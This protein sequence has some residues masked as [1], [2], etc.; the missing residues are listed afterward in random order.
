VTAR[1]KMPMAVGG[2]LWFDRKG[3]R[4]LGEKRIALLERIDEVGSITGAAKAVGLSYK[5]AWDAVDAINNMAEESVV[6]R[7]TGGQHGGGSRLTDYGR[8]LVRLYRQLET[9]HQR[10]LSRLESDYPDPQRLSD[11]LKAI[12]M[13]TSARNQFRGKVKAVRRG[14][15]NADV[16][17]DLGDGVE[18]FA[19]ITN[20]AVAELGLKRGRDAVAL[21]KASFVVLATGDDILVSARNRLPGTVD[22][23]V[24]GPV[25]SEVKIQLTGMRTLVAV[26][27]SAGLKE[28]QL[29]K[30]SP[31]FALI[32][33]SHVLIAVN[34]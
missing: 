33:A 24:K 30:G 11:L 19:N 9:G 13:K 17:L 31:V 5:G 34:D 8:G 3:R 27:S 10:V 22:S 15:V 2:G 23:I 26:I 16:V 14:A 6:S 21:I 32:N 4:F 18:V 29:R 25:N 1:K 20:D 28:L 7:S 12:T